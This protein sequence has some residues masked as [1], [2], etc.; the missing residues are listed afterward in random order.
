MSRSV[1]IL[2]V[3]AL[4]ALSLSACS[5]DDSGQGGPDGD[6]TAAPVAAI[7][8]SSTEP[9]SIPESPSPTAPEPEQA[10][11]P[12][13]GLSPAVEFVGTAALLWES[14][15]DNRWFSYDLTECSLAGPSISVQG[16]GHE[17][18]TGAPST[19]TMEVEPV[20]L[21]HERTGT[22]HGGGH[23]I[24]TADD[25]EIVGDGRIKANGLPAMFDYRVS[26]SAVDFKSAWW[27]GD[28]SVGAGAIDVQCAE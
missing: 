23:V 25:T 20:E 24:F 3:L 12:D 4:A 17:D 10:P 26:T 8:N 22:Y 21:L 5:S 18:A 15:T 13:P 2:S 14:G 6:S 19:L 28:E 11:E 1:K 7:D 27:I 9:S 16:V